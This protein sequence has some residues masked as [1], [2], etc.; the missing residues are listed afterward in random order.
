[1][2]QIKAKVMTKLILRE[3]QRL[4]ILKII[5]DLEVNDARADQRG[6]GDRAWCD[7]FRL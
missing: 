5:F 2:D 1:M 6:T 4:V 3:Y 7:P